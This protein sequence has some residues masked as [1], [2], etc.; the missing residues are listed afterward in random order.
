MACIPPKIALK[1]KEALQRGDLNVDD[2]LKKTADE[3]EAILK[4]IVDEK[5]AKNLNEEIV[6][7]FRT[8]LSDDMAEAIYKETQKIEKLRGNTKKLSIE[9]W[10]KMEKPPKWA[11]E[12]VN[13]NRK[14]E[15]IL[16]PTTNM[17]LRETASFNIKEAQ[18]RIAAQEKIL[19]KT[20]AVAKEAYNILS[21]GVYKSLK[22]SWDA[23]YLLRQ[24][25]KIFTKSPTAWKKSMEESFQVWKNIKST[26]EMDAA[27][28]LFKARY[29]SHPHYDI[30]VNQGKLSFGAV[31]DFFPTTVTQK[32]PVLKNIFKASDEA[33]TTFSQSA[34]FELASD[35]LQKQLAS[36]GT[37]TKKEVRAITQLADSI[38]GRGSLGKAEAIS[39]ALNDL[40]FSARFVRSQAD[41]FLMPFNPSVTPEIRLEAAKHLLSTVGAIGSLIVTASAFTDVETN[42]LSSRFGKMKIGADTYIDLTAGLGS[43]ITLASKQILGKSKSA[44]SGRVTKLNTGE[45]GSQTR[46]SVLSQWAQNKLAP[47]PGVINT[48]LLQGTDYSGEKPTLGGSAVSVGVPITAENF[49]EL[50]MSDEEMAVVVAAMVADTLGLSSQTITR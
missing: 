44:R 33:F 41:T 4:K 36:K 19:G 25:F 29:L 11:I 1:I 43:Y 15:E 17:S 37:L 24:G 16:D 32:I 6:K 38:T 48:A 47:V 20:G 40:F 45:F 39:G 31:E 30:L 22:A 26:K 2:L 8:E 50:L 28:D 21:S 42:P 18:K 10:A 13:L 9:D 27:M 34:R 5:Q 14:I 35:M 46:G 23:S 12:Y 3:R 7:T 49:V